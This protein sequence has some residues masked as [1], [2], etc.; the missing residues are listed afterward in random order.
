MKI[1]SMFV[2]WLRSRW[3]RILRG[4]R[5]ARLQAAAEQAAETETHAP[6]PWSP[7]WGAYV[8]HCVFSGVELPVEVRAFLRART[9]TA[10]PTA[11][12]LEVLFRSLVRDGDIDPRHPVLEWI[13]DEL[14]P[15]IARA[16]RNEDACRRDRLNELPRPTYRV[17]PRP[18]P[19]QD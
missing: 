7:D 11:E 17:V 8:A 6:S 18:R 15:I 3:W 19:H 12:Q 1:W 14:N 2:F 5:P 13:E 16:R 9:G 10:A 4:P